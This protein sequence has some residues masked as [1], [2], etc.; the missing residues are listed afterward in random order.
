LRLGDLLAG[1][2]RLDAA[3]IEYRKA[4]D[5]DRSA[6]GK[7]GH[8]PIFDYKIAQ[9]YILGNRFADAKKALG[10]VIDTYPTFAPALKAM[11]KIELAEGDAK[12][13]RDL[14][15]RS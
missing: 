13:A 1:E 14:L 3:V 6:G 15:E 8:A 4:R 7:A 9:T 5:S 11:G 12:K 2:V 10:P